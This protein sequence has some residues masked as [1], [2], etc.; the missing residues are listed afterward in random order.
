MMLMEYGLKIQPPAK[1][2]RSHSVFRAAVFSE[3]AGKR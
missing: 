2:N 1:I 3:K